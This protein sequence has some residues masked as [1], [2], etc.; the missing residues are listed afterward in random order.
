MAGGFDPAPEQRADDAL[1]D[2]IVA[3]LQPPEAGLVRHAGRG[4]GAAGRAVDR[5]LAV[6]HGVAGMGFGVPR[7]ARPQDMAEAPDIG[8]LRMDELV[9]LVELAPQH[10]APAQ[11][12]PGRDVGHVAEGGLGAHDGVEIPA[13]GDVDCQPP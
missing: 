6:E 10:G 5:L 7:R 4:P 8:L 13:I 3:D 2:E 9:G 11:Q 1:V 12:V